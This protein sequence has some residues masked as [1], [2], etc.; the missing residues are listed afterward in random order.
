[1]LP[2]SLNGTSELGP[3]PPRSSSSV[4]SGSAFVVEG[5]WAAL[6]GDYFH[7]PEE[8][9]TK[10]SHCTSPPPLLKPYS[11]TVA[12]FVRPENRR[13][14][15][16]QTWQRRRRYIVTQS[17]LAALNSIL[18][19]VAFVERRTMERSVKGPEVDFHLLSEDTGHRPLLC[20]EFE[21]KLPFSRPSGTRVRS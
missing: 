1:M 16:L 9:A 13:E 17:G 4:E 3:G 7:S 14:T 18:G 11:S 2:S 21:D 5:K 12:G 8:C 20:V 10:I 15:Q 19:K 6:I